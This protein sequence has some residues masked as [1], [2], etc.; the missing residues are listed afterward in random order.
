MN[1]LIDCDVLEYMRIPEHEQERIIEDSQDAQIK[2]VYALPVFEMCR[3]LNLSFKYHNLSPADFRKCWS[4][5]SETYWGNWLHIS[6]YPEE[7][8][9]NLPL[10]ICS[11]KRNFDENE[12]NNIPCEDSQDKYW[13]GH[14]LLTLRLRTLVI[15]KK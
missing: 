2:P 9:Y 13:D 10:K 3:A 15:G 12:I 8:K 5:F 4:V 1:W 11:L 7:D 6:E 14:T